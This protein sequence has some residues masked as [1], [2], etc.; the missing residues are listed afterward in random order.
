MKTTNNTA[1][2]RQLIA[3]YLLSLPSACLILFSAS[4][5]QTGMNELQGTSFGATG[6]T[7]AWLGWQLR[8]LALCGPLCSLFLCCYA[9]FHMPVVH[10]K[11][12]GGGRSVRE[13]STWLVALTLNLFLLLLFFLN[14]QKIHNY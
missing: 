1:Y 4:Q 2:L 9:L 11:K 13:N 12:A 14:E 7:T 5:M 6:A 8:L 3:A 10:N